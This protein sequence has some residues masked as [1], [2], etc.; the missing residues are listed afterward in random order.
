MMEDVL[1][2]IGTFLFVFGL[3]LM[4]YSLIIPCNCPPIN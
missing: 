3:S 2:I 1:D 4:G